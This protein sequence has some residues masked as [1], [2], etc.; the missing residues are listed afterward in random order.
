MSQ[1]C[2]WSDIT[3]QSLTSFKCPHFVAE[4]TFKT[5]A[6]DILVSPFCC[7][8]DITKQ[9]LMIFLC[10]HF[11]AEPYCKTGTPDIQ[12]SP[13]CCWSDRFFFE[14]QRQKVDF[15]NK[16][17]QWHFWGCDEKK[18]QRQMCDCQN[19]LRTYAIDRYILSPHHSIKVYERKDSQNTITL[20]LPHLPA[21]L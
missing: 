2:R 9:L 4:A 15:F 18:F 16:K 19:S 11:V 6:D 5:V 14:I 7:W 12:M 1:F 10:P 21:C 20:F 3:K 13:F 17:Y 8:N